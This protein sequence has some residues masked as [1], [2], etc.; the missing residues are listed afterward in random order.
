MLKHKDL[1][2]KLTDAQKILILSDIQSLSRREL[3]RF[4][5]SP[6]KSGNVDDYLRSVYPRA[7][8][9]A[10]SFDDELIG[11]VA[12]DI[13]SAM[14]KDGVEL[15]SLPSAKVKINPYKEALSEDPMLSSNVA[16]AYLKAANAK[17]LAINMSEC[18]IDNDDVVWMDKS[19]N[20][21]AIEEHIVKP[22]LNAVKGLDCNALEMSDDPLNERYKGENIKLVEKLSTLGNSFLICER[23]SEKN[24]V[25]LLSDGVVCLRSSGYA[26]D[27][28]H[29]RYK[30][31]RRM[32]D[33]GEL[34]ELEI[35][36][37]IEVGKAIST[38]MIDLA[39][40]RVFDFILSCREGK[41]GSMDGGVVRDKLAAKSVRESA[42]M[43][44][45]KS[46]I[47]PLSKKEKLFVIG[48]MKT[49]LGESIAE[50]CAESL[51][52]NGYNCIGW[53]QGYEISK[54]RSEMS[55]GE[56]Y[57]LSEAADKI[58][59]L[60]GRSEALEK[61]IVKS[62]NLELPA[63]QVALARRLASRGKNVV[64]VVSTGYGFDIE[65]VEEFDGIITMS[66]ETAYSADALVD[67]LTGVYNPSG[68]LASTLYRNT[69]K[70]FAKQSYYRKK[71]SRSGIFTGYR[72]YDT[73]GYDVGFPFGFGMGYSEFT[74]SRPKHVGDSV[75]FTLKNIGKYDATEVVQMYVGLETSSVIRPK[76]ELVHY[77][78]IS[79]KAGESQRVSMDISL[80][81]IYD[82]KNGEFVKEAGTYTVY[83][84]SSVSDI[85]FSFDYV[86]GEAAVSGDGEDV[87]DY[88]QS[89]SNIVRDKY[90]LEANYK[91]MKRTV[92]NVLSGVILITLAVLLRVYC[93]SNAIENGF[94]NIFTL[95]L[96]LLSAGYF[97]MEIV[98]RVKLS[99]DEALLVETANKEYFDDAE[100]VN[101]FSTDRMFKDEFESDTIE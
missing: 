97:I 75:S 66:L 38:E 34:E 57:N 87:I 11:S 39:V 12:S 55:L 16:R 44:K 20:K 59:L 89:A 1:V 56:A 54:S 5:L 36:N 18:S 47:L 24:T 82:E 37:E 49:P 53:A 40:D 2:G 93:H 92:R 14:Y 74:Y 33:K 63:N 91:L 8:V 72:Y 62:R 3:K 29:A 22:H 32:V 41:L 46:K 68:R 43:L 101:V 64:A 9:I 25:K 35:S 84:G 81:E 31:L 61:D 70:S 100:S 15:A 78:R 83:V 79:L 6:L 50:A 13:M 69:E 10:N 99:K 4:G 94:L 30:E 98:D 96:A 21:R 19:P 26:I 51:K 27:S 52:L 17:G 28:A 77:K 76:K 45:N 88:L 48:D 90:T 85:K 73:A 60:L 95:A 80:P 7:S 71:G 67:I 42:V 58:V 86:G 23:A 65:A